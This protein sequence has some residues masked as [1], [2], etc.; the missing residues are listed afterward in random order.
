LRSV[1]PRKIQISCGVKGGI[2]FASY[3]GM[4]ARILVVEDHHRTLENVC[5]FLRDEGFEV[6][7][8]SDGIKALEIFRNNAGFDVVICDIMLPELNGFKL[9]H[10]IHSIA[11]KIPI[12]VM[13]GNPDL[14]TRDAVVEGAV[15]FIRKPID[16]VE[17]LHSMNRALQEE[18]RISPLHLL[19]LRSR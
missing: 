6:E 1:L 10:H 19:P 5:A 2:A 14:D 15:E 17:L 3:S 13:T 18:S 7:E 11:P 8:A 9:I 12:I 16:F 4:A